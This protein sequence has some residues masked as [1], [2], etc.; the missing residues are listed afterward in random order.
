[1]PAIIKALVRRLGPL[2]L[3]TIL[4]LNLVPVAG[5]VWLGWDAAQI[6]MLYWI[7]NLVIGATSFVRIV[8]AAGDRGTPRA[9]GLGARLGTG[10]FFLVHYG[11]FCLVHGGFAAAI[12]TGD[13]L[14]RNELLAQ[15]LTD[16]GFQLAIAATALI[17]FIALVRDWGLSGRWRH[18]RPGREMFSPY[19]RIVVLHVTVIVGAWALGLLNAPAGAVLILCLMKASLELVVAVWSSDRTDATPSGRTG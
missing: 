11:I 9:G 19:G 8:T 1:M 10:A 14:T 4:L 6:L 7:E 12:A 3:V 18:G 16:R 2:R 17:Q 5:V 13:R 15:L